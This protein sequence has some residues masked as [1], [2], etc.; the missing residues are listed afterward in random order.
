MLNHTGE[1]RV[2]GLVTS[3]KIGSCQKN[4]EEP[5]AKD[6]KLKHLR[7]GDRSKVFQMLSLQLLS[8]VSTPV[9][10]SHGE[11]KNNN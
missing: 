6:S 11:E 9:D 8:F 4:L 2:L 10:I 3:V 7:T 5:E 1:K